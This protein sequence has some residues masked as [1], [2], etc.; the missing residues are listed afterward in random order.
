M[1]YVALFDYNG[2]D[3]L[4]VL[5]ESRDA[6]TFTSAIQTR[7]TNQSGTSIYRTKYYYDNDNFPSL[8]A[9]GLKI[10]HFSTAQFTINTC[11]ITA[12]NV[13]AN[14]SSVCS[15]GNVTLQLNNQTA[16]QNIQWQFSSDDVT[17]T[18]ISNQTALTE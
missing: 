7:Y 10:H 5:I 2:T 13:T 12:G 16:G 3:N 6:S 1:V 4:E 8:T 18:D 11:T 9:S 17:Y 14:V 15:G